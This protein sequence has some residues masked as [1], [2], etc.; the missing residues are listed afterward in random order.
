M[1]RFQQTISIPFS[2]ANTVVLAWCPE[3]SPDPQ[4][5]GDVFLGGITGTQ[6]FYLGSCDPSYDYTK[7]PW[8]VYKQVAVTNNS[9]LEQ[10]VLLEWQVI[11]EMAPGVKYQD[12][13]ATYPSMV[14]T[15]PGNISNNSN[16]VMVPAKST[17]TAWLP[18][19]TY[20]SDG[21]VQA[22]VTC[23]VKALSLSIQTTVALQKSGWQRYVIANPGS[24]LFARSNFG[25]CGGGSKG[26]VFVPADINS[27]NGKK[28]NYALAESERIEQDVPVLQAVMGPD[29]NNPNGPQIQI[30]TTDTGIRAR[31]TMSLLLTAPDGQK[32]QINMQPDLTKRVV[33]IPNPKFN[34]NSAPDPS[35]N[36]QYILDQTHNQTT[37]GTNVSNNRGSSNNGGSSGPYASQG[38]SGKSGSSSG[39]SPGSSVGLDDGTPIH[40][41]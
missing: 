5:V 41:N 33:W 17:A 3:T 40:W 24:S 29:P 16:L 6:L 32:W 34:S 23:H 10:P 22:E 15:L 19:G 28:I 27:G 31:E 11:T 38:S 1:E 26:P 36:P 4:L 8:T 2:Q 30:G 39:V 12:W 18:I 7:G 37:A 20:Q 13:M 35:S 21:A 9:T 14:T 25:P